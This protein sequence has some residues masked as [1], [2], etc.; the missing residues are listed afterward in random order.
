MSFSSRSALALVLAFASLMAAAAPAAQLDAQGR[1]VRDANGKRVSYSLAGNGNTGALVPRSKPVLR[2]STQGPAVAARSRKAGGAASVAMQALA[3]AN[4]AENWRF[5]NWGWGIGQGG[6]YPTDLD[7]NGDDEVIMG[8]GS[9]QWGIADYD[10]AKHEYRMLWKSPQTGLAALR[11]VEF[12]NTKYVWASRGDSIDV[13]D[14]LTRAVL[15]HITLPAGVSVFSFDFADGNNDG[16]P[17]VV[18]LGIDR[19]LFFDPI[20]FAL[21]SQVPV[22]AQAFAIGNV[23][24]DPAREIVLNDGRVIVVTGSNYTLQYQH[25]TQFGWR[26]ALGDVDADGRDELFAADSWQLIQAWD[27]DV[28]ASKWQHTTSHDIAALRLYDVTGDGVP[29][30]LYGDGQWG[31]I[32][33]L[34]AQTHAELWTA[35]NP[36]HGVTDIGVFDADDDGQLELLWGAGATSSGPDYMYVVSVATRAV[37]FQS[38]DIASYYT[39][40]DV[41]DVDNDGRAELVVASFE[42]ESG[43][44]DGVLLIFDAITHELE[45]RSG[46]SLFGGIA[47]EGVQQLRIANVDADAQPEIL[48][49]TSQTY[50]GRLFVIDGLTRAVE[51][52][53]PFG[54]GEPLSQVAVADVDG[55]GLKDAVVANYRAHSGAT[56]DYLQVIN[57]RDGASLWKSQALS[58]YIRSVQVTDVGAQ[59]STCWQPSA[60]CSRCAGATSNK[61]PAWPTT[62]RRYCRWTFPAAPPSSWSR[63]ARTGLSMCWTVTRSPCSPRAPVSVSAAASDRW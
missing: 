52:V 1:V 49:A 17:D 8:L 43:Y 5:V 29:E 26:L 62:T 46:T 11:L 23:D 2:A 40:L 56:G 61:S 55:D 4:Y 41:G 32:H 24:A 21:E 44:A 45:Y 30:L 50:D 9:A 7:A 27:L 25:P 35:N 15:T 33:A 58:G 12:G 20:T 18:A 36:D 37:E 31:A 63:P 60:T 38:Y 14:A 13:Y 6:F 34:N 10:A 48:V 59:V 16:D 51:N 53:W 54:F 19:I 28:P 42:S 39:A 22:G 47:W 57:P 3:P